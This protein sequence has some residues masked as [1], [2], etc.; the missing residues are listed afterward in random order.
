MENSRDRDPYSYIPFGVGSRNCIGQ[1]FAMTE[2]KMTV[3]KIIY[4]FEVIVVMPED[5]TRLCMLV[6]KP[7]NLF[8]KFR[9]RRQ[10][11]LN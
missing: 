1:N 2:F 5:V 4:N 7:A 10:Q 8:L 11:L 9:P 3:A 6:Q